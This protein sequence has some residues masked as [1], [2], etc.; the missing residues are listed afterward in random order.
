MRSWVLFVAAALSGACSNDDRVS[1]G[2][3]LEGRDGGS[4]DASVDARAG[5][6]GGSS[7]AGGGSSSSAGGG[8]AHGAGG[9]A[10]GA[11]GAG[12]T[13]GVPDAALP[14]AAL[15]DADASGSVQDGGTGDAGSCVHSSGSPLGRYRLRLHN[16]MNQA[17]VDCYVPVCECY[18]GTT[19]TQDGDAILTLTGKEQT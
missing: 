9:T 16:V 7:S 17:S 10:V 11:S 8:T 2:N 13:A 5:R 19:T 14:D 12:G 6:G 15:P 4:A 3:E 1:G 18:P